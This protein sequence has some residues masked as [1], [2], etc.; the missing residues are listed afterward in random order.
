M[1]SFIKIY[2]F[3]R[4]QTVQCIKP[5]L[6]HELEQRQRLQRERAAGEE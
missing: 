5:L 1:P 4:S 6:Q 3:Q 2:T